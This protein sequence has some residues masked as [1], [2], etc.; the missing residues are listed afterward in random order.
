MDRFHEMRIFVRIMERRSFTQA[1]EDLQLPRATVTNI[2]KRLEERLGT[3]LLE[4]TTRL[5]SPNCVSTVLE[6][7]Q[8]RAET[9]PDAAAVAIR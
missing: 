8:C 3:R 6:M 2:M 7:S 5:V 9:C 1:A 4:R